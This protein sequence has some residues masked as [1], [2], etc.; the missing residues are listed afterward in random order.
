VLFLAWAFAPEAA[1][2]AAGVAYYPA[3][4]WALAAP[5]WLCACVLYGYTAYGRRGGRT[6][7]GLR[8][9]VGARRLPVLT[10]FARVATA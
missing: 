7:K 10:P 9:L 8:A 5:S 2:H 1:L 3:K 6:K 4:W